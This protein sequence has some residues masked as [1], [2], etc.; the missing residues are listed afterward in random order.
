[1]KDE[2]D[3]HWSCLEDECYE[4]DQKERMI[5]AYE[6]VTSEMVNQ[7]FLELFFENPR[8]LHIKITSEN[9]QEEE[10][11]KEKNM[12]FYRELLGRPGDLVFQIIDEQEFVNSM[13]KYPRVKN[14]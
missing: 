8:R 12:E 5:E 4:F 2:A 1:M 6:N 13:E 3:T 9:H 7:K 14:I 11:V 10:G